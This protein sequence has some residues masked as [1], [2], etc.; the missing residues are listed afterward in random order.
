[1]HHAYRILQRLGASP[2]QGGWLTRLT[3]RVS[4]GFH[5]SCL[6]AVQ[7]QEP[8]SRVVKRKTPTLTLMKGS[9]IC[10]RRS[11]TRHSF[12]GPPMR[13]KDYQIK[14]WIWPLSATA[15]RATLVRRNRGHQTVG[16]SASQTARVKRR[17][18][19]VYPERVPKDLD[20]QSLHGRSTDAPN[21]AASF[22]MS[23]RRG[24][25]A[26]DLTIAPQLQVEPQSLHLCCSSNPIAMYKRQKAANADPC[27]AN[28]NSKQASFYERT[29]S[30]C[31]LTLTR[32]RPVLEVQEAACHASYLHC[33]FFARIA[34]SFFS[35][36]FRLASSPA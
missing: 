33:A 27:T 32:H 4:I 15:S 7:D 22:S 11:S 28:E 36:R 9:E 3:K 23:R 13:P 31:Q 1:M 5:D 24:F 14:T 20:D 29:C 21:S 25:G 10:R 6:T 26:E 19:V 30:W 12:D 18:I 34:F 8:S 35:R 17:A 2:S 16:C